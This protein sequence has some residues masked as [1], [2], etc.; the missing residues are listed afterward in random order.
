[1]KLMKPILG[2]LIAA[3]LAP[4]VE[5]QTGIFNQVAVRPSAVGA[6]YY[7]DGVPYTTPQVFRWQ[8]GDTHVLRLHSPQNVST[9]SMPLNPG[10]AGPIAPEAGNGTR[11][12]YTREIAFNQGATVGADAENYGGFYSITQD[13]NEVILRLRVWPELRTIDLGVS[14]QYRMR[15]VTTSQGCAPMM[16]PLNNPLPGSCGPVPGFVSISSADTNCRFP[17]VTGDYWCA[18]GTQIQ[19]VAVPTVGYAFIDWSITPGQASQINAGG[20]GQT[21]FT[22]NVPMHMQ[23]NFG[24]R[25]YYRLLTEPLGL[26]VVV[27]RSLIRTRTPEPQIQTL[28]N[29]FTNV[30]LGPGL[31]A[32]P[33]GQGGDNDGT[34]YCA[35]WGFNSKRLLAA[36][37]LQQDRFGKYWAFEQITNTGGGQNSEFVVSGSNLATNTITWKFVPT[38]AVSFITQPRLGLPVVVN[39]RTWP[40]Y[41]FQFGLNRE[42]TFTA[43]ME[44]VDTDGRRWRFRGWSNGGPATQTIKVTNEMVRDGVRLIANYEPLNKV[45]IETSPPGL[46]VTVNGEPCPHPCLLER[47]ATESVTVSAVPSATQA[48]VLR[49]D[50]DRWSDG[51][52]MTRVV[53]FEPEVQR[54]VANYRQSYLLSALANPRDGANFAF[55]PASADG[56]YA[57]NTPVTV[58]V[59]PKSGFEFLRWRGD[60]A[61]QFPSS[62]I[63]VGGPRTVIAELKEVPFLD[64]AGVRNAA[65][66]GPQDQGEIG[67]LAPGS[68]ITVTGVNLT[69][70]EEIGPASP[71]AQ[72][73]GDLVVRVGGRFLPLSSVSASQVNA[74]LPFDLAAG[75]HRVTVTRVGQPELSA[76][77]DA[78]RNAPGLFGIPGTEAEN[79]PPHAVALRA[80]G[81]RVRDE[82][83]ARAGE[84]IQFL[85]TGVGPFRVNPPIGFAI[86]AGMNFVL[87]DSVEVLAGDAVVQ[88][89]QAIATPGMVGM[90][91]IQI[92]VG[93]QFATGQNTPVRIRVNGKES[94]AVRL[95]VR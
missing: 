12:V 50:F 80:D 41:F 71:Q 56:F 40:N 39:N 42:F 18:E 3:G 89:T 85:A 1:M 14:K 69:P 19:L 72:T 38:A 9:P 46:A 61:G 11:F 63:T 24:P 81:S 10:A 13:P 22:L 91:S 75:R 27:D 28:C 7:V 34:S 25:K 48:N 73:L 77:F 6:V 36:P 23:A 49:M 35:V 37:D 58:T 94:N 92:R 26:D 17:A 67:K 51:G 43:P 52:E 74:Q 86:P 83:P 76:E 59:Q 20:Y 32:A 62:T 53:S 5:A 88:P 68:L 44:S 15:I 47:L 82:N 33:V 93:T 57:V 29:Q 78:V 16:D 60:T 84:L 64:P 8:V 70:R 79:Q 30:G 31:P 45:S 95:F 54:L 65:G 4:L 55:S 87:A 2:M 90:T 21:T 66:T